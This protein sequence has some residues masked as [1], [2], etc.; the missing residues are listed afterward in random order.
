MH[1]FKLSDLLNNSSGPWAVVDVSGKTTLS[2]YNEA[3]KGLFN[4]ENINITKHDMFSYLNESNGINLLSSVSQ[5]IELKKRIVKAEAYVVEGNWNISLFHFHPLSVET[6][7]VNLVLLQITPAFINDVHSHVFS[8]NEFSLNELMVTSSSPTS[9]FSDVEWR[10]IFLLSCNK[11]QKEIASIENVSLKAIEK[12]IS[13][14][15]EKTDC[16][17][18]RQLKKFIQC[19]GW[20]S[21]IPSCILENRSKYNNI[22]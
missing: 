6:D 16:L 12:R 9:L 5:A 20:D 21:Y 3:F 7:K 17:N 8:N 14:C 11:T 18:T 2:S 15:L 10:T 22:N 4:I 19:N 1:R 13:R